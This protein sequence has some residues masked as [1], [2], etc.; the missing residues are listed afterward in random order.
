MLGIGQGLASPL[1]LILTSTFRSLHW[2]VGTLFTPI[3][4][5]HSY[6]LVTSFR[7]NRRMDVLLRSRILA[8]DL[9]IYALV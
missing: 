7:H 9:V 2:Q 8:G 4:P 1:L 5:K 3:A 6:I